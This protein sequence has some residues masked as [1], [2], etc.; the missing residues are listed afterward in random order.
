MAF[1]EKDEL[2]YEFYDTMVFCEKSS[3]LREAVASTNAR[4][5]VY[6]ADFST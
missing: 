4:T 6:P 3:V 1:V 5:K 2:V